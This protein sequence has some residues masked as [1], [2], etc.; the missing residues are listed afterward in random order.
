MIQKKMKKNKLKAKNQSWCPLS[1]KSTQYTCS[2][3]HSSQE[4]P[5]SKKKAVN[6]NEYRAGD[7]ICLFCNNH[8][9]SFRAVCNR[10]KIQ[11]K[12]NNLQQ[13][14]IICQ[15][16]KVQSFTSI[17]RPKDENSVRRDLFKS[18]KLDDSL[19]MFPMAEAKTRS[20]TKFSGID[21]ELFNCVEGS[22]EKES[23]NTDEFDFKLSSKFFDFMD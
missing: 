5:D 22:V 20:N 10:C 15:H 21:A 18:S 14:L 11:T 16:E 8:N 19:E 4:T 3:K 1:A 9:Y 7:W 13:A 12:E 2:D 17:L 6:H 23:E